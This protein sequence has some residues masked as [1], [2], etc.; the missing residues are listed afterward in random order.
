MPSFFQCWRYAVCALFLT[1]SSI[2][3]S[4][5]AGE[6]LTPLH[7][8]ST[9]VDFVYEKSNA[10][11]LIV[12]YPLKFSSRKMGLFNRKV[13]EA[14]YCPKSIVDMKD[15]AWYAP[16]SV[17]EAEIISQQKNSPNPDCSVTADYEQKAIQHWNLKTSPAT[18]VVNDKG[19][20]VFVAYG[21]LN[22]LQQEEVITLLASR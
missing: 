9:P 12:V 18:I 6:E 22:K 16:L 1:S 20:V 19:V 8:Q 17:A 11:Q 13:I 15:R 10:N 21:V 4:L 7:I 3:Y 2:A 14:G 5:V